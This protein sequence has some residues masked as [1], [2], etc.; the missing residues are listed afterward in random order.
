[1][2]CAGR[3]FIAALF[4]AHG[5][6][7]LVGCTAAWQLGH[8]NGVS[9]V[10]TLLPDLT[11]GSRL[12][13]LL[14]ALWLVATIAFLAAAAGLVLATSWWRKVASGAALLSLLLC[15]AWWSSAWFG[16]VLSIAILVA[17]GTSSSIA[18]PKGA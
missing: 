7:H 17:L 13:L 9:T 2:G 3:Y 18:R 6:V 14:G 12:L 15:V 10:P 8:V 16:A 4:G 11:A 5:L 1:M